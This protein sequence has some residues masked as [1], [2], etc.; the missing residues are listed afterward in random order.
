MAKI[1]EYSDLIKRFYLRQASDQ[2]L[3]RIRSL[4]DDALFLRAWEER[5]EEEPDASGH[6]L[7]MENA[8]AMFGRIRQDERIRKAIARETARGGQRSVPMRGFVR[9]AAACLLFLSVGFYLFQNRRPAP[10][11]DRAVESLQ[12]SPGRERAQIVLDDGSAIDLEELPGDTTLQMDGFAIRKNAD[13]TIAYLLDGKPENT[14]RMAYN[15]IVTPKGGEY[16]LVL[17]DGTKAWLN[18]ATTLRYP[19]VFAANERTVQMEGEAYFEVCRQEKNGRRI[20]FVVETGGQR[21]EVLGTAFNVNTYG[22]RVVTTLVEGAVKLSFGSTGV[23]ETLLW[24][25][26][27]LSFDRENGSYTRAKVDPMYAIS[28]KDGNFAFDRAGIRDVMEAVSR[29]YD[30]DVVYKGERADAVFS[31]VLSRY[32]NIDK[33]LETIALTGEV[34]FIREGRMVHVLH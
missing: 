19:V 30:V 4:L 11:K 16:A 15:S 21:I 9:I 7:D 6:R 10:P 3:A 24:P 8:E 26:D 29:W 32:E 20:P 31:G 28:W 5:W 34:N 1:E 25:N 2:D 12:V 23:P 22:K 33:M 17:P 18:A 14:G 13:G 27:Q